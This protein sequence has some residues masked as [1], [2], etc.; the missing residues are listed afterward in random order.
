MS[1]KPTDVAVRRGYVC[2]T[3]Q[4]SLRMAVSKSIGHI[5]R[6]CPGPDPLSNEIITNRY[7]SI[8]RYLL[9]C[10]HLTLGN[11]TGANLRFDT[12]R[13]TQTRIEHYIRL[14][15]TYPD[16]RRTWLIA[17][18]SGARGYLVG[19][20]NTSYR[21]PGNSGLHSLRFGNV[22]TN[23]ADCFMVTI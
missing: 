4:V 22:L 15:R 1:E 8:R 17:K 2:K 11:I 16:A 19:H 13:R 23:L 18:L 7:S 21:T 9:R 6:T 20:V 12:D 5:N 10:N 3:L 14:G